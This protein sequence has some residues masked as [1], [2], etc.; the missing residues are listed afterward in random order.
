ME[1][2]TDNET[3]CSFT[4]CDYDGKCK[5]GNYCYDK[6]LYDK[7]KEYED[8]EEQGLLLRLPCKV[9]QTVYAFDYPT[10]NIV[11]VVK[12]AVEKIHLRDERI[13]VETDGGFY[14]TKDFGRIVFLTKEEAEAA[15][16]KMKEG[17][18]DEA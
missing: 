3:Y 9:G 14:E 8:L 18:I 16:A 17:V 5:W 7:L 4:D 2:L 15:L 1:R 10:S 12:E 6:R 11:V 13:V